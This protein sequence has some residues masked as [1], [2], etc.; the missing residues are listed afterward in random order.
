[1]ILNPKTDHPPGRCFGQD[2]RN[3]A[4]EAAIDRMLFHGYYDPGLL[5]RIH[6]FLLVHW[7]DR[8]H[9]ENPGGDPLPL[10]QFGSLQTTGTLRTG[11]YQQYI[12]TFSERDCSPR[13][14]AVLFVKD[15]RASVPGQTDEHRALVFSSP[16]NDGFGFDWVSW[17]KNYHV[18]HR[19]HDRQVLNI[20]VRFA[21]KSCHQPGI[22]C[23]DL[24]IRVR[25][26]D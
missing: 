6:D 16:P 14:E 15:V 25:L 13:Y 7:L 11:R 1:M 26:G 10:E 2:F 5:C 17:S 24:H 20:L 21:R 4:A 23:T 3:H 22:G 8:R 12:S 19:A 18:G 9:V